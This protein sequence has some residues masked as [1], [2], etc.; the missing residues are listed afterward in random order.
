MKQDLTLIST[1]ER[2]LKEFTF[3]SDKDLDENEIESSK[4]RRLLQVMMFPQRKL[5]E[6]I[7]K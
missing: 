1:L 6:K 3:E 5:I 7:S 4:L 2:F